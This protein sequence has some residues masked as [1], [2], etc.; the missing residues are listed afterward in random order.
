M[1]DLVADGLVGAVK[2]A[3]TFDPDRGWQFATFARHRIRGEMI[4][5]LRRMDYLGRGTRDRVTHE[6]AAARAANGEYL[7][8]RTA[9]PISLDA[10]LDAD[11]GERLTIGSMLVDPSKPFEDVLA[12]D[13]LV[14]QLMSMLRGEDRLVIDL[15][16]WRGISLSA[17]AT[18]WNVS[19]SRV[20][21][22]HHHALRRLQLE[23]L[24]LGVQPARM[25]EQLRRSSR[26]AYRSGVAADERAALF[27]DPLAHWVDA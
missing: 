19:P 5:G 10:P 15:I 18:A 4:D 14:G 8:M 20:S 7:D 3:K 1:D 17:I 2:A 25:V 9:D 11:E 23:A 22:I 24:R 16:Y 6:I 21:Q 13:E 12:D 26:T 27:G